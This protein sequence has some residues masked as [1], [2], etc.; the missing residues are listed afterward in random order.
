[1]VVL[2]MPETGRVLSVPNIMKCNVDTEKEFYANVAGVFKP[3]CLFVGCGRWP[4]KLSSHTSSQLQ[5]CSQRRVHARV[6]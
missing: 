5:T 4:G 6:F 2:F 3:T 1:M